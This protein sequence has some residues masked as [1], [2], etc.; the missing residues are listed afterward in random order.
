MHNKQGEP[1]HFIKLRELKPKAEKV[2][3]IFLADYATH[4]DGVRIKACA[5][6]IQINK[7]LEHSPAVTTWYC[8]HRQCPVC[9]WRKSLKTC[10]KMHQ[11]FDCYPE[12]KERKWLYL[13]LTV[14]NCM[15]ENL[16]GTIQKM[17]KGAQRLSR[18][19]FWRKNVIGGVRF[20]EVTVGKSELAS[21]H[22]H[23]HCLL[24]VRP[25]MF[26]GKNYVSLEQWS[27]AW[28]KALQETYTPE[29]NIRR[30][31]GTPEDIRRQVINRTGYSMKPL[32]MVP[33]AHWLMNTSYEL[34][35]LRLFEPFGDLREK[36]SGLDHL[37]KSEAV[38]G[39]EHMTQKEAQ[40][41]YK[42]H[43]GCKT[44]LP[45]NESSIADT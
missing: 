26:Q 8:K 28:E 5:S 21:A 44:Y 24:S 18:Q 37:K 39:A 9:Q 19:A 29:V 42:W 10:S 3:Q 1:K 22:P 23:F 34:R 20:L 33:D 38:K 16:R 2:A 12:L 43:P 32:K 6:R 45:V 35:G 31:Q 17:N 7:N 40:M 41:Y 13:T 14:R 4:H 36:L 30:F 11:L 25:S 27:E 15:P